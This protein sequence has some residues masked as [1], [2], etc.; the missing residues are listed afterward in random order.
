[1]RPLPKD[2]QNVL[3]GD[4]AT[5]DA[6]RRG[7]CADPHSILGAHAARIGKESGLVV[8]AFHPDATGAECV[9]DDAVI[10]LE[11]I[12]GGLFA[13]FVPGAGFPFPYWLRFKFA[14]GGQW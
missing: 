6:L 2:E 10:P 13:S 14:D 12:G 7:R 8:R 4:S 1:M 5:F 11:P 3:V 9:T